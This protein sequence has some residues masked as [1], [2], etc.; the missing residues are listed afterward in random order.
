MS[1][2]VFAISTLALWVGAFFFI[3]G[4]LGLVR[5]ADLPSRLHA[6]TKADTVG[7]MFIVMGLSIRSQSW[8]TS[9]MLLLITL[10]V[11]LSSTISCQLL[12]RYHQQHNS[13]EPRNDR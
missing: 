2:L 9:L 8:S 4:S 11:I 6:I 12:A 3:T 10:L 1:N 5:F 13:V 7:L